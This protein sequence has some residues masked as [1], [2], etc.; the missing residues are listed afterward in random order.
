VEAG[1]DICSY[2]HKRAPLRN[3]E[4]EFLAMGFHFAEGLHLL[5]AGFEIFQRRLGLPKGHK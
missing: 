4:P 2:V 5:V 1:F 3:F